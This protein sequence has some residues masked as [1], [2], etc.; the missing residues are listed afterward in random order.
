L[1]IV[2]GYLGSVLMLQRAEDCNASSLSANGYRR[3][4]TSLSTEQ[5]SA[6]CVAS[7]MRVRQKY[8][9]QVVLISERR[10]VDEGISP[11]M[12]R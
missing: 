11:K 5:S 10:S 7:A 12:V 2:I 6:D 4:S 9:D 8:F 1:R 3:G